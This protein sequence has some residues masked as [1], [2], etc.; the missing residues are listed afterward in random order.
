MTL[1]Y[2]PVRRWVGATGADTEAA[3]REAGRIANL[4]AF[5]D[6]RWV[7]IRGDIAPCLF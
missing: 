3:E 4:E 1:T 5:T 7:T 2:E 6:T